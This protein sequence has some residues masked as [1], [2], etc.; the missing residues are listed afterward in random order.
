[1]AKTFDPFIAIPKYVNQSLSLYQSLSSLD[2]LSSLSI[3][4]DRVR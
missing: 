3:D 1:M 4:K 2:N